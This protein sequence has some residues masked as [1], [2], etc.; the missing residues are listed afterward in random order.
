[1]LRELQHALI[2]DVCTLA[3]FHVEGARHNGHGEN[4]E[5]LGDLRDDRRGARARTTTH[6]GGDE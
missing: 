3:A 5:L 2:S 1:M 4:A 6:A